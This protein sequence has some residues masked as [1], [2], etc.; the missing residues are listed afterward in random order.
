MEKWDQVIEDLL[1]RPNK[2][3]AYSSPN[4][5]SKSQARVV[6]KTNE[7]SLIANLKWKNME[8]QKEMKNQEKVI[9]ELKMDA[10]GTKI[11]ELTMEK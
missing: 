9:H 11:W 8:L 5:V 10:R 2:Y 1:K 3:T 7:G 6:A 4:I